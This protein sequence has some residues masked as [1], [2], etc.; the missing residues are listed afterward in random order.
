MFAGLEVPEES[1]WLHF[2]IST[3]TT[4]NNMKKKTFKRCDYKS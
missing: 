4:S 1:L 2:F 3:D